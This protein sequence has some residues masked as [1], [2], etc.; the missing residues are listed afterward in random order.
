MTD[1]SWNHED[2]LSLFAVGTTLFRN[3][4]RM[5][6]C[7]LGGAGLMM[8][9]ALRSAPRYAA[10]ASFVR[11]GS[12]AG[13][14]GLANLAGQ[15]GVAIPQGDQSQ[16]PEFYTL[17]LKTPELLRLVVRDTFVI[18]EAGSHKVAALDL[19]QIGQG[20]T[21]NREERGI[22]ELAGMLTTSFGKTTGVVEVSVETRWPSLSLAI[23]ADLVKGVNDFNLRTR[24]TQAAMERRFVE[25]RLA[26]AREDLRTAEDRVEHFLQTNRQFANS[27]ELTTQRDRLQRDVALEQQLYNSLSQAYEEARIREVRDTP[28]IT[29]IQPPSVSTMPTP[30][31]LALRAVVGMIVGATLCALALLGWQLTTLRAQRGDADATYFVRLVRDLHQRTVGRIPGSRAIG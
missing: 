13:R 23:V 5:V 2:E 31:R 21:A 9:P 24:Q 10:S 30:R 14:S 22:A 29:L 15:F 20:S 1:P 25:R 8:L 26:V 7:M 11:Q 19:L 17:L 12:E 6:A 27:A 3:R 4:W 16:S 28:L 18:P